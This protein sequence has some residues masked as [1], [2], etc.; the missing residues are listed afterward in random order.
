MPFP[1]FT[2]AVAA[3]L[4]AF[5]PLVCALLEINLPD[6]DLRLVDGATQVPWG[7]STFKGKDP[8]YGIWISTDA[9]GDGLGDE[10]PALGLSFVPTN[11]VT[12]GQLTAPNVQGSRC[13]MWFA[14][15]DRANGQVIPDPLIVF[16]GELD[17]PTVETGAHVLRLDYDVVSAFERLFLDDE[18]IRLSDAFHQSV[19]A[20]ERGLEYMSGLVR[21]IIWGPGDRPA[22]IAVGDSGVAGGG[23]GG[24]DDRFSG[25]FQYSGGLQ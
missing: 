25:R 15:I 7:G 5:N 24:G 6:Y 8:N 13:R 11:A 10:V 22:G 12:A 18:G 17:Q 4:T 16:D 14:V 20:G 21:S 3:A 2:P 23:A 9:L 1:G 19:W